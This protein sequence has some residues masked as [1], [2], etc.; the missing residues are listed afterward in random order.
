MMD[1]LTALKER[2]RLTK[3]D[4]VTGICSIDCVECRLNS[5]N[6]GEN[7]ACSILEKLKPEVWCEIVEK[8]AADNPIETRQTRFLQRYPEAKLDSNSVIAICPRYMGYIPSHCQDDIDHIDFHP[9][10]CKGCRQRYWGEE[11][12]ENNIEDCN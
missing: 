10:D 2:A 1:A 11:S 8:W 12:V 9:R 5:N 3:V 4:R 6:N 7:V